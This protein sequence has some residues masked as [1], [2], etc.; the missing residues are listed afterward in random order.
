MA[1]TRARSGSRAIPSTGGSW[2]RPPI[3]CWRPTCSPRSS[4]FGPDVQ[5]VAVS[6]PQT[7]LP[8]GGSLP[9]VIR[10]QRTTTGGS[11]RPLKARVALY[12]AAGNRLAQADERLL[13]DRHLTPAQWQ[14][15]DQP[16]NV[17]LLDLPPELPPGRYESAS[18][19]LR[20]RDAGAAHPARRCR[21]S[22]RAG[23]DAG[24]GAGRCA[25]AQQIGH[26]N[27]RDSKP[28]PL[29]RDA[30]RHQIGQSF[31]LNCTSPDL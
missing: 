16:L 11:D 13:N 20:C 15:A 12:D 28:V 5:T 9:V 22:R 19:C 29:W 2:S 31:L 10:W 26:R 17:Y 7:A 27:I 3:S 21:E 4:V 1:A 25:I 14:P 18:P 8:P 23:G 24:T 6:L 30:A